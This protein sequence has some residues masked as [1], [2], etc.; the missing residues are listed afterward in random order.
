[1]SPQAPKEL[2]RSKRKS[3]TLLLALG[4]NSAAYKLQLFSDFSPLSDGCSSL[5]KCQRI[6][7]LTVGQK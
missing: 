1:M 5:S 4:T 3:K 6:S 2:L 7:L